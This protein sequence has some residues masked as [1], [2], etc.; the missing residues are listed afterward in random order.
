MP[1]VLV[2]RL[3]RQRTCRARR[4][5]HD[6]SVWAR[7]YPEVALH[8]S[9]PAAGLDDDRCFPMGVPAGLDRE[10]SC[11][12][13]GIGGVGEGS[14]PVADPRFSRAP[15]AEVRCR[16]APDLKSQRALRLPMQVPSVAAVNHRR[17]GPGG[18]GIGPVAGSPATVPGGSLGETGLG[19]G[20]GTGTAQQPA[21][22]QPPRF[23]SSFRQR[24][25]RVWPDSLRAK[26]TRCLPRQ[27]ALD[28]PAGPGACAASEQPVRARGLRPIADG[29]ASWPGPG[30]PALS[31]RP[32]PFTWAVP[33]HW[34][35]SG[36]LIAV[37][38][39]AGLPIPRL[40]VSAKGGT[41]V[42]A[43]G[44]Q[45]EGESCFER[46]ERDLGT[47]SRRQAQKRYHQH[48]FHDWLGLHP[49]RGPAAAGAFEARRLHTAADG[50][51][52]PS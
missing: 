49:W 17:S 44:R 26:S 6:R 7:R 23:R 18:T 2:T 25:S 52:G 37:L 5:L 27:G 43:T 40:I 8:L 15:A 42:T 4:R 50:R 31:G 21:E 35:L 22:S 47:T 11:D 29:V 46:A 19:P 39:T 24:V 38:T 30:P 16:R 13:S 14:D 45:G 32:F 1:S 41:G 3:R 33:D 10:S 48:S 51:P 12:A 34:G 28:S 36:S 20:I 9:G